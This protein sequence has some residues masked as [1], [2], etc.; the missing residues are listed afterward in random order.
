MKHAKFLFIIYT[1][2]VFASCKNHESK[3]DVEDEAA[4]G[5]TTATFKVWG[6][7]DMCQETIEGSLK[8]DGV[9]KANWNT[10]SKIISVSY[11]EK[12]ISLDQIQKDIAASGYD[13]EKY[14]GDDRAYK[15][16]PECCQYERK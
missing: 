4:A 6:N 2:C 5:M 7:C 1:L 15:D 3:K 9:S 8:V 13:T 16:L 11:D 14:K 10:D 12:K